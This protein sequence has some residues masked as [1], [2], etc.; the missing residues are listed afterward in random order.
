MPGCSRHTLLALA[1]HAGCDEPDPQQLLGVR[2]G[3][4]APQVRN[5]FA[6]A[7]SWESRTGEDGLLH[8]HWTPTQAADPVRSAHF[9]LHDGLLVAVRLQVAQRDL[10]PGGDRVELPELVRIIEAQGEVH[11]LVL[12]ARNCPVHAAEVERL[13]ASD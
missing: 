11:D 8:L 9:E 1:A 2:L 4:S 7:G 10:V 3:M 6:H 13:L 5:A 12:I